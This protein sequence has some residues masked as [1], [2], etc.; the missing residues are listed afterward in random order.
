M[1]LTTLLNTR[2]D[3]RA[4]FKTVLIRPP[5]PVFTDTYA[6]PLTRHW[7]TVGTAFNYL[8]RALLEHAYRSH[9]HSHT[10]PR[11]ASF[12]V[13]LCRGKRQRVRIATSLFQAEAIL[14]TFITAQRPLGTTVARACLILAKLEAVVH[15]GTIESLDDIAQIDTLDI[16]DLLTLADLVPLDQF[17]P[18]QQLILNPMFPAA[19]LIG[20]ADAGL[21]ID[22]TLVEIKTTIHPTLT[23]A[24]LDQLTASLLLQQLGGISGMAPPHLTDLGVYFARHGVLYTFPVAKLCVPGGLEALRSWFQHTLNGTDEQRPDLRL[25]KPVPPAKPKPPRSPHM[26][27]PRSNTLEMPEKGGATLDALRPA[28]P[29]FTTAHQARLYADALLS[30]RLSSASPPELNS[31]SEPAASCFSSHQ[32]AMLPNPSPSST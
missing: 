29:R 24:Q 3:L 30:A 4:A 11:V 32:K 7:D 14:E 13:Q 19:P 6:P 2:S 28:E 8:L 25:F 9:A 27:G 17:R 5:P 31:C 26:A 15:S 12:A 23:S 1:S 10:A 21:L 22:T 18:A 16:Q 20:S